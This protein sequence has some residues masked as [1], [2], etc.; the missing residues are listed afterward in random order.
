MKAKRT[1]IEHN[2]LTA[3]TEDR[4]EYAVQREINAT[5]TAEVEDVIIARALEI[6]ARRMR[7]TGVLM[8]APR[9]SVTGS[10]CGWAESR[11]RSSAASG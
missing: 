3:Q 1:T 6:L 11:M 4:A 2:D 5:A 9:L 8:D 7:S 10:A